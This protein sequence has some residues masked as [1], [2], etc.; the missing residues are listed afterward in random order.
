MAEDF[1][2]T[3][4]VSSDGI[5]ANPMFA[6]GHLWYGVP[7]RLVN[8]KNTIVTK[9][10]LKFNFGKRNEDV[11]KTHLLVSNPSTDM[12]GA[13]HHAH[14]ANKLIYKERS[15]PISNSDLIK[16]EQIL[17]KDFVSKYQ[18]AYYNGDLEDMTATIVTYPGGSRRIPAIKGIAN[19]SNTQLYEYDPKYGYKLVGKDSKTYQ[20][21]KSPL[22]IQKSILP[23]TRSTL[24]SPK[25]IKEYIP[26]TQNIFQ[27]NA[28]LDSHFYDKPVKDIIKTFQKNRNINQIEAFMPT[29][30]DSQQEQ[31]RN[32]I[33]TYKFQASKI[34]YYTNSKQ[35]LKD[36]PIIK[37]NLKDL[38]KIEQEELLDVDNA[39]IDVGDD[40]AILAKD[41][42]QRI[43]EAEHVL[44]R[45]RYNSETRGAYLPQQEQLLNKAYIHSK[46]GIPDAAL[47]NEKGAVNQQLRTQILDSFKDN[48][49]RYP[50]LKELNKYIDEFSDK[51]LLKLLKNK[52]NSYGLEYSKN[53]LNPKTIKEALKYIGAT[54][55]ILKNNNYEKD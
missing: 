13:N 37:Q 4:I 7:K 35:L 21:G 22:N 1:L 16:Y 17:G 40:Y 28:F 41:P 44:Q 33:R 5:Y 29:L 52:T 55:L 18:N 43:H 54:T 45:R 23:A 6:Q 48:F 53:K 25:S 36:H 8:R 50:S 19:K 32:F 31:L 39:L 20:F 2:K 15:T 42:T 14:A 26:N 11:A 9:S 51:S 34:P 47:I 10:G 3:G 24:Y 49:G 38:S 27:Y 12:I 46:N 30:A